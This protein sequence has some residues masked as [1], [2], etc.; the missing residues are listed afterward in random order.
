MKFRNKLTHVQYTD[1]NKF[2]IQWKK[3]IQPKQ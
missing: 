3:G 2:M 1:V